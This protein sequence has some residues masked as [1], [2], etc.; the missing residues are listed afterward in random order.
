MTITTLLMTMISTIMKFINMIITI[1]LTFMLVAAT[2]V[3]L[4]ICSHLYILNTH[5]YI[6]VYR[7]TIARIKVAVEISAEVINVTYILEYIL[8]DFNIVR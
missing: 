2:I 5:T 4:F 8:L 3:R 6:C 7:V 1:D